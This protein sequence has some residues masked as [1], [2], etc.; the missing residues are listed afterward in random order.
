MEVINTPTIQHWFDAM[1]ESDR[2]ILLKCFQAKVK[3]YDGDLRAK[4]YEYLNARIITDFK[5]ASVMLGREAESFKTYLLGKRN[6]Q[7]IE[8]LS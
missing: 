5:S 7:K 8:R 6:I 3:P 1:N 2:R 4:L